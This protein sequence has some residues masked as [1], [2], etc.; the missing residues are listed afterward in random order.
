MKESNLRLLDDGKRSSNSSSNSIMERSL[1]PDPEIFHGRTSG[2]IPGQ[3]RRQQ[4]VVEEKKTKA[5]G[6]GEKETN[7]R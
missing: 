1:L 3:N 4:V 5:T 7:N 6:K 2:V